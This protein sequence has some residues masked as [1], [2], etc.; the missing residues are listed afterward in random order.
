[1]TEDQIRVMEA[2]IE[3]VCEFHRDLLAPSDRPGHTGIETGNETSA[4]P[5]KE[6]LTC[7]HINEAIYTVAS[8]QAALETR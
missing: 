1:M 2:L 5:D 3:D 6:C 8:A 4:P 7:G